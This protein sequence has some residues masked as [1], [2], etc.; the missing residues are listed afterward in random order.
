MKTS[1][2]GIALIK[3]HEGYREKPYICSAGKLTVGFGHVVQIGEYF[4][5]VTPA[6]AE[7]ILRDDLAEAEAAVNLLVKT[8]LTQNE[9]DALV[10]F[11]FNLGA[12]RLKKS[13]LLSLINKSMKFA[14]AQEFDKWVFAGGKKLRGLMK[15]REAEKQ[16]FLTKETTHG[17]I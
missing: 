6:Q 10:S 14:A 7:Q 17:T 12:G 11:T 4:S 13:T 8:R 15:R 16:L 3:E 1:P 5:K 2:A 9:F